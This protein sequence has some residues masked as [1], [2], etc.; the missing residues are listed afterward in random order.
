MAGALGWFWYLHSHLTEGRM[1]LDRVL[2]QAGR[3]PGAVYAKALAAAGTLAFAQGDYSSAAV[4][5]EAAMTHYRDADDKQGI[6]SALGNLGAQSFSLGDYQQAKALLQESEG[7]C[8]AIGDPV[9]LADVLTTL[10]EVAREL[11]DYDAAGA[12]YEEGL[13]LARQ[14]SSTTTLSWLLHNL[15]H[16]AHHRQDD[17]TAADYFQ[18][19]LALARELGFKP[20]VIACLAGL[21][22]VWGS[23]GQPVRAAQLLGAAETLLKAIHSQLDRADRTESERNLAYVRAQLDEAAFTAAWME[24]QAMTLEQAVAYALEEL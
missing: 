21:A 20:A 11:G 23:R 19:G 15:G 1:W 13:T 9:G 8:R 3:A 5:H 17:R 18:Q 16:V 22:G 10:G 7:L 6:A 4:L 14:A 24:G 12:Y 2:R